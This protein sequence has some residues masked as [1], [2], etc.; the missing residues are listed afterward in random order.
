MRELDILHI[1][2]NRVPNQGR[3][4]NSKEDA[5]I[6]YEVPALAELLGSAHTFMRLGWP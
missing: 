1:L 4:E 6:T 2:V 3:S 5:R